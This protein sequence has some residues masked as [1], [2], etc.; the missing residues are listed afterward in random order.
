MIQL[1]DMDL[2]DITVLRDQLVGV[3]AMYFIMLL[4]AIPQDKITN[5]EVDGN[6]L[7]KLIDMFF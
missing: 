5:N 3:D 7:I 2:R 1:N 6:Y 4:D